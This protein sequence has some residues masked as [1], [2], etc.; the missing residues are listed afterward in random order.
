MID[1]IPAS[2]APDPREDQVELGSGCLDAP[3]QNQRGVS[4]IHDGH[5]AAM[6]DAPPVTQRW[7]EVGLASVGYGG[8]RN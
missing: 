6:V 5:L 2:Y 3:R 8:S 7:G 1:S 4:Q